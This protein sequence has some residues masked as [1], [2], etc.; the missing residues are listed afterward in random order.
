MRLTRLFLS[1]ACLALLLSGCSKSP[2]SLQGEEFEAIADVFHGEYAN[3]LVGATLNKNLKMERREECAIVINDKSQ[4]ADVGEYVWPEIDFKRYSVV[5]G[6]WWYGSGAEYIADQKIRLTPAKMILDLE[7]GRAP[8][9]TCDV[10]LKRIAALYPK[11]PNRQIV[12]R[13]KRT[14]DK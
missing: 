9:G 2:L 10:G 6:V 5:V 13:T 7:I 1:I 14:T 4:L 12:V 3:L 8:T 11:L